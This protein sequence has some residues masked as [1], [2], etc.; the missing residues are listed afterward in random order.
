GTV[1][2]GLRETLSAAGVM[3]YRVLPFERDEAGFRPPS[4]YPRQAWACV[5]THDLPP[6]AGWWDGVDIQE[7]LDLGLISADEAETAR[8]A[9]L[10]DRHDLVDA[11]IAAGIVE[12][13]GDASGPL[14][15]A[16]AG[17]IHAYI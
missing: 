7:R 12:A 13:G 6:L 5:A 4:A 11:L 9:R 17:A 1:P 15:P 2:E 10:A 16:L 8:A 14:D 3:S